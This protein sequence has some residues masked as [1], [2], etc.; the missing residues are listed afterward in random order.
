VDLF[1]HVWGSYPNRC[2]V[3]PHASGWP[4]VG[5]GPSLVVA[6]GGATS[7]EGAGARAHRL[8]AATKGKGGRPRPVKGIRAAAAAAA[9]A[10]YSAVPTQPHAGVCVC[11]RARARVR[12]CVC[13]CACVRAFLRACAAAPRGPCASPGVSLLPQK[14]PKESGEIP[15]FRCEVYAATPLPVCDS[16]PRPV[17]GGN[18]TPPSGSRVMHTTGYARWPAASPER[19]PFPVA[20]YSELCP[21]ALGSSE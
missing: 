10:R 8:E 9:A 6:V 19:C 3:D 5:A 21:L 2:D 7:Q 13:A 18:H 14:P 16:C 20:P 15:M 17:G 11:A 12:G 4:F 1:T